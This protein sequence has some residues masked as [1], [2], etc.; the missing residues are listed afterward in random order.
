VGLIQ[1]ERGEGGGHQRHR[2]VDEVPL[3]AQRLAP[4][5]DGGGCRVYRRVAPGQLGKRS[6][7]PLNLVLT[8]RV[9]VPRQSVQTGGQRRDASQRHADHGPVRPQDT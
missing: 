6:R 1:S 5:K 3:R 2:P 7:V 4:N 8:A 9:W